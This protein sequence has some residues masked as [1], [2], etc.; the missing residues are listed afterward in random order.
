LRN[1][2]VIFTIVSCNYI[3]FAATLMQSV[4]KHHPNSDRFIVLS[5]S[6]REFPDVDLAAD[7]IACDDLRIEVI[8]GMKL[9]YSVIE[10]NT[11]VKPFVFS[12]LFAEFGYT[13]ACYIDPDILLFNPLAEVFE[14]LNQ[15]NIVLTPHMM[16]SLQDGKEPSDLTIMKSGVYNLGFLGVRNDPHS[17][18]LLQWWSERL[19]FHC[20]IDIPGH[21]FTDQR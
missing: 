15:H 6:Y 17:K 2:S 21:M 10:F 20:R 3:S 5:D 13:K 12:Y 7:L 14:A 4:R 19:K 16:V 9:W 8:E 18:L 1:N 11:A